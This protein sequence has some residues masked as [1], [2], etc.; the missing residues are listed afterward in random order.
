MSNYISSQKSTPVWLRKTRRT[1]RKETDKQRI[2][3]I[4]FCGVAAPI[5]LFFE[6]RLLHYSMEFEFPCLFIWSCSRIQNNILIKSKG[7]S[8][9]KIKW[10]TSKCWS[11][12]DGKRKKIGFPRT[13]DRVCVCVSA[14]NEIDFESTQLFM[15]MRSKCIPVWKNTQ[16][17]KVTWCLSN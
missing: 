13:S 7:D 2:Q 4:H 6:F 10:E 15:C 3:T 12:C 9:E 16:H 5:L 17:E 14:F 11:H 1:N 8:V